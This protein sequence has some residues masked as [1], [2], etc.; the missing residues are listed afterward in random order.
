L[1]EH[2]HR[3]KRMTREGRQILDR[4][5][6]TRIKLAGRP[7]P[8]FQVCGYTGVVLAITLAMSL[9]HETGLS[10]WTMG[11]LA[12]T[13]MATFLVLAF[14]TKIITGTEQLIYYHHEIAIVLMTALVS[15]IMHQPVLRYLDM[16]ILGVGAFLACGRIGCLMVGCCHGRACTWGIRYRDEH[17]R[18]G[19]APYLVGI[20][21]FPLQAVESLW[22]FFVAIAG[23][24]IVLA[25]SPPGTALAWYTIAY[26]A[27]RFL[28]EF[29]RGDTDRPYTLGFSQGQ[30]LS[31]WLTSAL[32]WAELSGHIVLQRWHVMVAFALPLIMLLVALRRKSDTARTFQIVHPHHVREIA[33]AMQSLEASRSQQPTPAFSEIPIVSTS[34]GLQIS[35]GT[36]R[37]MGSVIS[38][39][40]IS[41]RNR[42]LTRQAAQIVAD[43]I[44][45]LGR[46]S[47]ERE[48][49]SR[50]EGVFHMLLQTEGLHE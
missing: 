11:L 41:C 47:T 50:E 32:V 37:R 3:E 14:L 21:L 2:H 46:V 10:Y 40:T 27:A 5:A 31:L 45:Q 16:T 18:E 35:A 36:T 6:R 38:Y 49:V 26:G 12:I 9:V 43:V 34:I 42:R 20:R 8:S 17:A 7:L 4:L 1:S 33:G 48:L 24:R 39:F 44:Q 29:V 23:V 28:F 15:R 19:F 25:G 13:A 30:W 22:V